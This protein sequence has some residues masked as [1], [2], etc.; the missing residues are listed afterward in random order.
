MIVITY[1]IAGITFRTESDVLI[2]HLQEDPFER[3]RGGDGEP[4]VHCRIRQFDPDSLTLPPLNSR[5][6][7]RIVRSMGFL[8]RWL[9]NPIFRFPEVRV[10]L[11]RCLDRPELVHIELAWNRAIIRNFARNEVDLFYPPDRRKDIADP[12]FVAGYRNLLATLLPN[13]S[14]VMIHGAGVVRN[15]IAA[16]FLAPDKGG[17]T[18]VVE[19]SSGEPILNDDHIILRQKDNVVIA[20]GT[21]LGPITSGPQQ[22]RIGGFFL[23]EKASRFDLIPVQAWDILQFLWNAHMHM[24][25]VLPKSLRVRAFEILADACYQA[26][27]YRMR[28]PK[29]YVDWDAVDAAMVR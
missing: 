19:R 8:Q 23:L 26:A 29:D 15:G 27:V 6:R 4:D 9:D 3:F 16:V 14:A 12:L 25:Y 20:H 22:A 5:E 28:F 13:F 11:Q 2:P 7:E 10:V 24:W 17:K 21:P 18:T 1:R